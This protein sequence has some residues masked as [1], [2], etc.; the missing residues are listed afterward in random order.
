MR[1][2]IFIWLV[3]VEVF[4]IS[5]ISVFRRARQKGQAP[6]PRAIIKKQTLSLFS[7]NDVLHQEMMKLFGLGRA[8][9]M[10]FGVFQLPYRSTLCSEAKSK[11]SH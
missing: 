4:A 11:P 8:Q 3:I 2:H 6:C 1:P 10:V 7:F 5:T 9:L